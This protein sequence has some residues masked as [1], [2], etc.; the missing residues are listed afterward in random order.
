VAVI[1]ADPGTTPVTR[2]VAET[3]ATSGLELDHSKVASFD[4]LARAVSRSV[5]PMPMVALLGLT[6]I[7][8]TADVDAAG[9]DCP[10]RSGNSSGGLATSEQLRVQAASVRVVRT[11]WRMGLLQGCAGVRV[12]A[13][14]VPWVGWDDAA[15]ASRQ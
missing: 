9:E 1:V 7:E 2:P 12:T 13:R 5:S 4:G 11:F 15:N 14:L 10:G 8:W 6:E 3:A